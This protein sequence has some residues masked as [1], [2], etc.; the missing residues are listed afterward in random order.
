MYPLDVSLLVTFNIKLPL[1]KKEYIYTEYVLLA[2]F[3]FVWPPL[4]NVLTA[5]LF[6]GW[7]GLVL[8]LAHEKK[9]RRLSWD[10]GWVVNGPVPLR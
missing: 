3:V 7:Y 5:V 2:H 10:G 9:K 8:Q 4:I 1:S 6:L